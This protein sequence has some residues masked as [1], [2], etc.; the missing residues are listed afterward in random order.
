MWSITGLGEERQQALNDRSPEE[1]RDAR[2]EPSPGP[3]RKEPLEASPW[4]RPLS[5]PGLAGPT[6]FAREE[7]IGS[8]Q[9]VRELG[10]GG[11]GCVYLAKDHSVG[12]RLVAIKVISVPQTASAEGAQERFRREILN[13]GRLRHARI[14]RI[15]TAGTHE[16]LPYYVMDYVPGR[17]LGTFL[18]E[19]ESWA[20]AARTETLLELLEDVASTVHYAHTR[21]ITHRDLKPANIMISNDGDEPIVLDFGIAKYV[22]D[23]SLTTGQVAPGTPSY[24][25]PEQLDARLTYKEPL[26]DVWA[27]GVIAYEAFTG[28]LPFEAADLSSLSMKILKGVPPRPRSLKPSLSPLLERVILS[29]LEKDPRRRPQRAQAVSLLLDRA[30]EMIREAGPDGIVLAKQTAAVPSRPRE[31]GVAAVRDPAP[32]LP[33]RRDSA[34]IRA[35]LCGLFSLVCVGLWS[36]S[37]KAPR[38]RPPAGIEKVLARSPDDRFADY[39][40]S[41][42][43]LS[44]PQVSIPL[45]TNCD[46]RSVWLRD[47]EGATQEVLFQV[48][49]EAGARAILQLTTSLFRANGSHELT[50]EGQCEEN[51][52]R[53]SKR[54]CVES[55]NVA[56]FDPPSGA[57][58]DADRVVVRGTL[59]DAEHHRLFLQ[60]SPLA[61]GDKGEFTIAVDFRSGRNCRAVKEV[62]GFFA[63]GPLVCVD[64]RGEVSAETLTYLHRDGA[65]GPTVRVVGDHWIDDP[66]RAAAAPCFLPGENIC[67]E[68]DIEARSSGEDSDPLR[69]EAVIR[70]ADGTIWR[71]REVG[72][73]EAPCIEA[74]VE[75]GEYTVGV[76]VASLPVA[77]GAALDRASSTPRTVRFRVRAPEAAPPSG[78]RIVNGARSLGLDAISRPLEWHPPAFVLVPRSCGRP[79]V[80]R[81][82]K[83]CTPFRVGDD[84]CMALGEPI[85][86]AEEDIEI[87][88]GASE[89]RILIRWREGQTYDACPDCKETPGYI[90]CPACKGRGCSVC[91][92]AGKVSCN[93]PCTGGLV[94]VTER[95][96]LVEK[97]EALRRA[98]GQY[99]ESVAAYQASSD[100]RLESWKVL[101]SRGGR[102]RALPEA[103]REFL[104]G[105][106][107]HWTGRRL[108]SSGDH[109]RAIPALRESSRL[110]EQCRADR[111]D[112]WEHLLNERLGSAVRLLESDA[113]S[114]ARTRL[115]QAIDSL[116]SELRESTPPLDLDRRRENPHRLELRCL[117]DVE[118]ETSTGERKLAAMLSAARRVLCASSSTQGPLAESLKV[119]LPS[120][121][122][123]VMTRETLALLESAREPRSLLEPVKFDLTKTGEQ[124]V[125]RSK[126]LFLASWVTASL[127]MVQLWLV[128]RG[129]WRKKARPC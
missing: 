2:T 108:M 104:A 43:D 95:T 58:I 107:Q 57:R 21:G 101:S 127:C 81:N 13:L 117:Q 129:N 68:Y 12:T 84:W 75:P 31:R 93:A 1:D 85:S 30:R 23:T 74:P 109:E 62:P 26:I 122:S 5:L 120:G 22:N 39:H 44:E 100:S 116:A 56:R 88:V 14:V 79:L 15:L 42:S 89:R 80:T 60:G 66:G 67:I 76:D 121:H 106:E 126:L 17:P 38:E 78:S 128:F 113:R 92:R 82:S 97:V 71:R 112:E 110:F 87:R 59:R 114:D 111:Q 53:V 73:D 35:V 64:Q 24:C 18:E 33:S 6:P 7:W 34:W 29:C 98:R 47:P 50:L 118:R 124:G 105:S 52:F 32:T 49:H 90:Q 77:E 11:M 115:N 45:E 61:V 83:P 70:L 41:R 103:T 28:Q 8:Y 54:V 96:E 99:E 27:L 25:A 119:V 72:L 65:D 16:G 94:P 46:I 9:I 36:A 69:I 19:C 4:S 37:G 3:A 63:V 20:E 91:H 48:Q 123:V 55:K 125:V 40:L 10:R 102:Y 86:S 51:A